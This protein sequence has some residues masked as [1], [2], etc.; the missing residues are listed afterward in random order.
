MSNIYDS[1]LALIPSTPVA[2]GEVLS[3][4][5]ETY[6]VRLVGGGE[7]LCTSQVDYFAPVKVFIEGKVIVG[8]APDNP[9]EKLYI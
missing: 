5:G 7:L 2:V 8:K 4:E 9:I 6:R 3:S 1:F